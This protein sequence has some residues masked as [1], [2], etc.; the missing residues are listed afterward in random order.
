MVVD[1]RGAQVGDM[2]Q[3]CRLSSAV[4]IADLTTSGTSQLL[5]ATGGGNW[6]APG[7]GMV[8]FVCDGAVNV[9]AGTGTPTAVATAGTYVGANERVF[10]TVRTGEKIAAI[11]A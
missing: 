7:N 8:S 2:L 5:Q 10:F 9:I 4:R 6:S 3:A 11:N 1:G